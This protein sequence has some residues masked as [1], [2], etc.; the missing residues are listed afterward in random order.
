MNS[1]IDFKADINAIEAKIRLHGISNPVYSAELETQFRLT[2]RQLRAVVYKLRQEKKPIGS[3]STGYYWAHSRAE[4]EPY[5]LHIRAQMNSL[6]E[7]L[8][9]VLAPFSG[10]NAVQEQYGLNL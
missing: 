5:V 9:N 2:D 10:N 3:N 1:E 4:I 7:N 8:D 6:Q